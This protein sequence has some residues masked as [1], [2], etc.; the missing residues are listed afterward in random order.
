MTFPHRDLLLLCVLHVCSLDSFFFQQQGSFSAS[1]GLWLKVGQPQKEPSLGGQTS[2]LH[3]TGH[4]DD[5]QTPNRKCPEYKRS[6]TRYVCCIANC[7]WFSNVIDTINTQ[8]RQSFNDQLGVVW[9][10]ALWLVVLKLWSRF[11]TTCNHVPNSQPFC[12][13]LIRDLSCINTSASAFSLNQWQCSVGP[14][15]A[16]QHRTDREME[17]VKESR[18]EFFSF[19]KPGENS[20]RPGTH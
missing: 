14:H 2:R 12:C 15:D 3:W 8:W 9:T 17:R 4:V 19:L 11:T 20:A 6:H 13:I 10:R 7:Y 18:E 1:G 5:E 16:K